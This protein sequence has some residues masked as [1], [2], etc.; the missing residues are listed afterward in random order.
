MAGS[1]ASS[2]ADCALLIGIPRDGAAVGFSFASTTV[3]AGYVG[4][5]LPWAHLDWLFRLYSRRDLE[6]IEAQA[7]W[8]HVEQRVLNLSHRHIG[9]V[10]CG[11]LSKH[12][13]NLQVHIRTTFRG[14][15]IPRVFVLNQSP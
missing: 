10:S 11:V 14:T 4:N 9:R 2:S 8:E 13:D 3:V 15:I 7:V 5:M 12:P 6:P 1:L